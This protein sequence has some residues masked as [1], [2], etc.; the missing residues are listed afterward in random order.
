MDKVARRQNAQ[1]RGRSPVLLVLLLSAALAAPALG[2]APTAAQTNILRATLANGLRVILVRN[3]VAP[4]VTTAVNYRV[5]ADETPSGFPGMAHAQEHMMFRGSPGLSAD[6]LANI[7]ALMGGRFD[8]DTRQ[9]VTQYFFTVPSA[10]LDVAL[11][12]EAIRMRAVHDAQE[13]WSQERGAIEQEVAQD[14]SNPQYLLFTKLRALFFAGTPYAHDGLGTTAS[15]DRTTGAMLHAFYAKWYAPNNAV[16]VVA[17][18]IAL[19][20]TLAEIERL[21]GAIPEKKLPP[22][23]KVTLRPVAAQSFA[24]ASD[25]PVGLTVIAFPM[26]GLASP[27]FP[28]AEVLADV[29]ANPRGDLGSLAPEGK[30]L[31]AEF[32]LDPL[33]KAGLGYAIAG[34]PA[35]GAPQNLQRQMRAILAAVAQKGVPPE[36]VA[37]AKLQER[38]EAEFQKN[39]IHGL[40]TT[41][42]EAVAVDHLASPDEDLARI[43][44]VTVA[45]VDRVA[46]RYLVP[47]RAVTGVLTPQGAG[48]PVSGASFGGQEKIA[49]GKGEP[50]RLPGWAEAALNR[51]AV[52]HLAV[53]PTV[54][55]LANGLTLI[56]Q[57]ETVSN[58]VSVYG[59]VRLRPQLEVPAGQEGVAE[60]LDQLFSYGTERLDRIA[61]QRALDEIGAD[62][63]GGSHFA[64]EVLADHFDRAVA[65]LAE[66]ELHPAL[67]EKAFAIVRNQ[68]AQSVAG[69]LSS[70]DYLA[71]RALRKGLFP[72]GDP[73][74][75]QALP[76]TVER[77][78]L[79]Q[80]RDFYAKAFRPD[81]TTIVV[82]GR[83]T[84]EQAAAVIERYFGSWKASGPRPE[85]ALPPVP[86]NRPSVTAIPDQSRV[87][88]NV[89]LAETVGLTRA[90]PDFYALELG[91]NVLGGALY[92]S[93][94]SRDLRMKDG[95]VY[96]V[97]SYFDMRR[98]RGLY[99]LQY[100]CD[101]AN[102]ARVH[103]IILRDLEAMQRAPVSDMELHRAKALLIHQISL[104]E[105]SLRGIAGVILD[106]AKLD[107]PLD[108]PG[109]AAQRYL[110]LD[111]AAVQAAFAKW[112]RPGDLVQVSQG[113]LPGFRASERVNL[114]R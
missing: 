49:L 101:P 95:L 39:S 22:R 66:N 61:F 7:G 103:G 17:G 41:W 64:V 1:R 36:L 97:G 88:D 108:E 111:A 73:A 72:V 63:Q 23:P 46:R 50:T 6:Q 79:P 27:D 102:V 18:D 77:L 9:T 38:R 24:L 51:L 45:D 15:F 109:R 74:L 3:T 20:P 78:T 5:G 21:F 25:L 87:Q 57:P 40:A 42:S 10:D 48:K 84:P 14:L 75:R 65:L 19:K 29:L 16:L 44:R 89:T 69:R 68:L 110:A 76:Q 53:H 13:D 11:H 98:R 8:A 30:A 96:S 100:A 93:R 82:I 106:L 92:A 99:V 54:T 33:P 81:L 43:E 37:A 107:L 71:L 112:V 56:V 12:V 105:A 85:T 114:S 52:P 59:D 31:F 26:P 34:F 83:V 4:V 32:A 86:A 58:T 90:N 62:E 67:S 60:L 35:G 94:L 104:S 80:L 55:R 91:N 2:N 28:A 70:P 47:A 113:P